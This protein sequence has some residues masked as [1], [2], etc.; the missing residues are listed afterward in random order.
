MIDGARVK[1]DE[2]PELVRVV[3][4]VDPAVTSGEES[5]SD[6]RRPGYAPSAAPRRGIDPHGPFA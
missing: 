4:A 6:S 3:V 5:A 1:P 2:V